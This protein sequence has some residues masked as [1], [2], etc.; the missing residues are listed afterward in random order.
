[1]STMDICLKIWCCLR[2]WT[3]VQTRGLTS[4]PAEV[5]TSGALIPSESDPNQR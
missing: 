1:M 5:P 3:R 2:D 4:L